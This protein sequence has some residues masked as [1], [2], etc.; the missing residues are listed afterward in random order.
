M[1]DLAPKDGHERRGAGGPCRVSALV[2]VALTT[3][4]SIDNIAPGE[5]A[6]NDFL[7]SLPEACVY[8]VP[9]LVDCGIYDRDYPGECA[10]GTY[11]ECLTDVVACDPETGE[12]NTAAWHPCVAFADC[13]G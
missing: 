2:L 6:C 9:T 1:R 5:A 12:P 13:A 3:P 8:S 7:A 10:I 11:F 4:C